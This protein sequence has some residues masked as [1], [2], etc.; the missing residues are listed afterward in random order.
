LGLNVIGGADAAVAASFE[1]Y[2]SAISDRD[3]A[4]SS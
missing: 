4:G 3:T 1:R 2:L